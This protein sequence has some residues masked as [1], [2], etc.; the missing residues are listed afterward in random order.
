MQAEG[1]VVHAVHPR[2]L[3][4]L[5][6]PGVGPRSSLIPRSRSSA[7][8]AVLD[9]DVDH[10]TASP[11]PDAGLQRPD[12]QDRLFC[13]QRLDAGGGTEGHR[14]RTRSGGGGSSGHEE[15]RAV[16]T[17]VRVLSGPWTP[18]SCSAPEECEHKP[19]SPPAAGPKE[20]SVSAGWS[21]RAADT[22]Q[23]VP[24]VLGPGG[25]QIA[26]PVLLTTAS[27]ARGASFADCRPSTSTIPSASEG[28][29]R[30]SD[31]LPATAPSR[32]TGR[33]PPVGRSARPRR[34]RPGV[35]DRP[36]ATG[37][38]DRAA[39]AGRQCGQDV[40]CDQLARSPVLVSTWS[41]RRG[42][43]RQGWPS[44]GRQRRQAG[45]AGPA[46][47]PLDQVRPSDVG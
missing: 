33:R 46:V 45:P 1:D 26:V 4:L 31:V 5:L 43:E 6:Q 22:A 8:G 24:A 7:G 36:E 12:R 14:G 20:L 9:R 32:R 37:S 27:R 15:P 35:P 40:S 21:G 38:Q 2:P 18:S 42:D 34:R 28:G 25:E 47:S 23:V 39:G 29:Q 19:P 11:G 44:V 10:L 30:D 17:P 16:E 3:L 13:H 41:S